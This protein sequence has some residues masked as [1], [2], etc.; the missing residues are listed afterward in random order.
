MEH[1]YNKKLF[2]RNDINT[3]EWIDKLIDDN[4]AGK[5]EVNLNLK[6]DTG[7]FK[8]ENI[9]RSFERLSNKYE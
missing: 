4:T 6:R 3:A 8:E 5:I 1:Q 9:C 2:E 7:A